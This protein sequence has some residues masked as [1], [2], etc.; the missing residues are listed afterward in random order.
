RRVLA[1]E[2]QLEDTVFK[3]LPA[4]VAAL[5]LRESDGD[6]VDGLTHQDIA[7]R[8]GVYRETATNALNE[9]KSAGLIQL[10][11]KHVAIL[12]RER[13]ARIAGV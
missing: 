8:L 12:D 13:L 7:E 1:A 5:L 10:G 2:R 11:R 4:R 9:L 3:G 6:S